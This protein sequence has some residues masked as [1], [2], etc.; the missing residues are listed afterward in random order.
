M[1]ATDIN[2]TY[3]TPHH[4]FHYYSVRNPASVSALR[5]TRA[6]EEKPKYYNLEFR[7]RDIQRHH[8]GGRTI[9]YPYYHAYI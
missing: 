7:K 4:H 9:I 5:L 3:E 8:L 6:A 2:S 1:R